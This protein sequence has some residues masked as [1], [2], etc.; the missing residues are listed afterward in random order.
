MSHLSPERLAALADSEPAGFEREHLAACAHCVRERAA[1]QRLLVLAAAERERVMPPLTN[2]ERVAAGLRKEGMVATADGD[3]QG[4]AAQRRTADGNA[5]GLRLERSASPAPPPAVVR[6]SAV[7]RAP[8]AASWLR[9]AAAIGL[10]ATGALLGRLSAGSPLLPGVAQDVAV[11]AGE[12]TPVAPVSNEV[13]RFASVDEALAALAASERDYQRA[14][15]WLA[16]NDTLA[17]PAATDSMEAYRMRLAALDELAAASRAALY[18][19]PQDPVLNR[20]YLS[21]LGAREATLRQ[22]NTA[23]PVGTRMVSY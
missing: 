11:A 22:M 19:A 21:T 10:L 9:A 4:G 20:Y 18:A 15:A 14:V 1:Y 23:L 17:S 12:E 16:E 5:A 2:W 8:I 7:R 3:P 13:R 6:P